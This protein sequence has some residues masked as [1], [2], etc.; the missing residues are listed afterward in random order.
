M[1]ALETVDVFHIY[2]LD[3]FVQVGL[4]VCATFSSESQ[5]YVLILFFFKGKVLSAH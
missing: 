3:G 2:M 4:F 5:I 1:D